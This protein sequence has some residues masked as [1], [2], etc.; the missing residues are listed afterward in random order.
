M[1]YFVSQELENSRRIIISYFVSQ[2][3][4]NWRIFSLELL[5]IRETSSS[6]YICFSIDPYDNFIMSALCIYSSL[7]IMGEGRGEGL[8]GSAS[9]A[10]IYSFSTLFIIYYLIFS[11]P[12]H[13]LLKMSWKTSD[14][15]IDISLFREFVHKG[16]PLILN[17]WLSSTSLPYHSLQRRL[18]LEPS[19]TELRSAFGEE[20]RLTEPQRNLILGTAFAVGSDLG[21]IWELCRRGRKGRVSAG[22]LWGQETSLTVRSF[23]DFKNELFLEYYVN[24]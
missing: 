6:N 9:S 10:N 11:F 23:K 7:P 1:F 5:R 22:G 21:V 24:I 8:W 16:E 20:R 18:W 19:P 12:A 14:C 2:E 15:F 13:F 17:Y 3:L 4:E